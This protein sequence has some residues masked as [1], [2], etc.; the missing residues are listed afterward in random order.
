MGFD[1]GLLSVERFG[2]GGKRTEN[3]TVERAKVA[4][5]EALIVGFDIARTTG[6][7]PAK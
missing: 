2:T 3:R 7:E 6:R 5:S 4:G 1:P